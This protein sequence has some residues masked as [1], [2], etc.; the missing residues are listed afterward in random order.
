MKSGIKILL[1]LVLLVFSNNVTWGQSKKITGT[2]TSQEDGTPMA[3]V[4]ITKK[5]STVGTQTS[6]DGRFT[7]D[8]NKGDV[9][10]F[11]STGFAKMEITVGASDV[12]NV[13]LQTDEADLGEVVVVG[14][15]TQKKSSLTASISKLDKRILETG[16]RCQS[17][18]GIG[19]NDCWSEGV[20]HFRKARSTACH[21][22]QGWNQ[23]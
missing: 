3:G 14:Y 8:A 23:F 12:L 9:L 1:V 17:C 7:I 21:N 22:T 20:N 4:S 19:W 15:G 10:I 2:V 18:T 6:A 5:G 16:V 13:K 11:T